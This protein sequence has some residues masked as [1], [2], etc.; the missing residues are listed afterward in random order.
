MQTGHGQF[1]ATT[2]SFRKTRTSATTF[3]FTNSST[4]TRAKD[5]E[6]A[7]RLA[8][9]VSWQNFCSKAELRRSNQWSGLPAC[10][11]AIPG[12][13][14]KLDWHETAAHS[15]CY[16]LRSAGGVQLRQDLSN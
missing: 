8:G 9:R 5:W 7:T 14:L 16:S 11:A 15:N 3:C 13:I 2:N 1:T 6:R 10:Y 12:G 4:A